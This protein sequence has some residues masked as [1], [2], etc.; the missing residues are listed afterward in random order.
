MGR[1]VLEAASEHPDLRVKACVDRNHPSGGT[2]PIPWGHD[3][4]AHVA[5]GDVVVEFSSAEGAGRAAELCARVGAGLVSGSTGLEPAQEDALHRAATQVPVVRSANFSLGIVALTAALRAALQLLPSSYDIEIIERHHRG[6]RDSPSGTAL[7]L[8][9]E[10]ATLRGWTDNAFRHGRQ[11]A[12]GPR[13]DA[14]LGLHAVRA[15][16]LV[17]DHAVLLAG[18]GEYLELRH[19]AQDRRA[20][21]EGALLAAQFVAEASPGLYTLLDVLTARSR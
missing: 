3:L 5:P 1:T 9:R 6:K 18:S 2:G 19:V 20:F 12:V 7:A 16:G 21:A 8:A 14:E 4:A 17:G 15:G 10:A 13:R 11:G